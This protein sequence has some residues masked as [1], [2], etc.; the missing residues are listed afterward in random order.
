MHEAIQE[1][2]DQR[3]ALRD[4]RAEHGHALKPKALKRLDQAIKAGKKAMELMERAKPHQEMC[5]EA[6]MII[7]DEANDG[8]MGGL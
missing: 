3:N 8:E 2:F 4:Y 6:W 7:R 1:M 5:A